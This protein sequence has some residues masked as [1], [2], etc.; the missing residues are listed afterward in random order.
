MKSKNIYTVRLINT[1]VAHL[2]KMYAEIT[3][4]T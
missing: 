1:E 2:F 4:Q 3:D